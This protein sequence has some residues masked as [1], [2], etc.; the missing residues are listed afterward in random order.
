MKWGYILQNIFFFNFNPLKAVVAQWDS[1]SL[2]GNIILV[3]FIPTF[4]F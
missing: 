1:T 4:L 3:G 2:Y